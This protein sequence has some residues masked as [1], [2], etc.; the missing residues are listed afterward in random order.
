MSRQKGL[1]RLEGNLDGISF[2]KSGGN[3]L[4]RMANGPSK[5]KIEND[6]AFVRVKENN[7]EFGGAA[8]VGKAFRNAFA[9]MV[10]NMGDRYF[11]ARLTQLFRKICSRG[12][13]ARGERT[14]SLSDHLDMLDNV[15][16]N[17]TKPFNSVCNAP[18]TVSANAN[19][20]EV[21]VDIP[22]LTPSV[23]ISAPSAATHFKVIASIG[24]ISN[25]EFDAVNKTYAPLIPEM[26]ALSASASGAVLPLQGVGPYVAN[27]VVSFPGSPLMPADVVVVVTL[28]IEFYQQVNSV[29]YLLGQSNAMKIIATL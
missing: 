26:N 21:T 23:Y 28:G 18:Y 22:D 25:Y 7:Q 12:A 2:Y 15:E 10:R 29:D 19:R 27:L 1:I 3:Y 9:E 13:G 11:S 24:S 17:K 4:A 16:F 14:I 6:P 5:G 20:N 8:S